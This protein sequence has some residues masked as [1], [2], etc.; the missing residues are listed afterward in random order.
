MRTKDEVKEKMI[1]EKALTMISKVGLSGLKMSILAKEV[2][3]ATGT[4]YIYF[5]DKRELINHLYLY[6]V[7]KET[8][9]SFEKVYQDGSFECKFKSALDKYI[10]RVATNPEVQIFFE[11]YARSPYNEGDNDAIIEE[12]NKALRPLFDLIE[13][14]QN[15]ALIKN[16]SSNLIIMMLCGA[17]GELSCQVQ[18]LKQTEINACIDMMWDAIAIH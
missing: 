11:Q 3:V 16:I 2:G 18:H 1:L 8:E 7:R 4:I 6:L 10:R 15:E 14:G 17:V 12:E 13:M 5:K 9:L